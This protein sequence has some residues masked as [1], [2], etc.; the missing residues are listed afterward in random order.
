MD[1][2]IDDRY[3]ELFQGLLERMVEQPGRSNELLALQFAGHNLERV[4]DRATNISERVIF[5]VSGQ[6][7]ELNPEPDDAS[8]L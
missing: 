5:M 2:L 8:L 3:L 6:M 7:Q 4:A 1:N